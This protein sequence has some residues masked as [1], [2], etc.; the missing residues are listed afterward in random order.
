MKLVQKKNALSLVSEKIR[1]SPEN[2]HQLFDDKQELLGFEI[3]WLKD[4]LHK[5]ICTASGLDSEQ[6]E[7]I[8]MQAFD[9]TDCHLHSEGCSLF[10]TLGPDHGFPEPGKSGILSAM[11]KPD[12]TEFDLEM[13]SFK[14]NE[15]SL[16]VPY[17]IHAFQAEKGKVLTALG[18][19]SPRIRRSKSEFDVED[20][21]YFSDTMVRKKVA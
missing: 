15:L 21:D 20:F 10:Q 16:V 14:E 6:T 11:Y 5:E 2:F 19:V 12:Q 8:L 17:Q 4:D 18:I 3:R 7:I 9:K 1:K 13:I